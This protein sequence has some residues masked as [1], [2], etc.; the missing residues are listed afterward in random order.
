LTSSDT[1]RRR[2]GLRPGHLDSVAILADNAQSL[3]SFNPER[4]ESAAQHGYFS[5]VA[6]GSTAV[7]T[8]RE[9]MDNV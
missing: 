9:V 3:A 1:R 7:K 6:L 5:P 4:A 8:E 2:R